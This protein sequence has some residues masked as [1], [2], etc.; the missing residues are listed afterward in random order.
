MQD[1]EIELWY[2]EQ[3]QE[4]SEKYL[5]SIAKGV[6]VAQRE[7]Y[8]NKAMEAM[9]KKYERMHTS[10]KEKQ[11]NKERR[12]KALHVIAW[13]IAALWRV[14]TAVSIFIWSAFRNSFR[15][16]CGTLYFKAGIVWTRNS[17]KFPD[18]LDSFFRPTYYFYIKHLKEPLMILAKP[19]V[20]VG[21]FFARLF[22]LFIGLVK[23][24]ASLL[25]SGLKKAAK[26]TAKLLAAVSKPVSARSEAISKQY[27]EWYAKRL[28][29]SLDRKQARKEAKEKTLKAKEE[30]RA[31]KI[32]EAA[33]TAEK[34]RQTTPGDTAD[35]RL[36]ENESNL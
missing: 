7:K 29:A 20:A 23:S 25:W 26:A 33:D 19:F 14:L 16:R 17:Y 22:S 11:R 36:D 4:L 2:E 18:A 24:F 9:T 35:R 31:A 21:R 12:K 13:P 34:S 27:N 1:E 32:G 3:K 28:Q 6:G 15:A 8:F 5:H 30:A 10:L